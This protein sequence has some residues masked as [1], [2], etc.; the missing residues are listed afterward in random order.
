MNFEVGDQIYKIRYILDNSTKSFHKEIDRTI[1]YKIGSINEETY[2]NWND[3]YCRLFIATLIPFINGEWVKT[4][5]SV[6][7]YVIYYM[8]YGETGH[9]FAY[10]V[11]GS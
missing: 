10:K 2:G 9:V 11:E 1:L 5:Y 8:V 6:D 3:G 7:G 4:E